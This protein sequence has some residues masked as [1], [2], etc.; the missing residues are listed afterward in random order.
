MRKHIYTLYHYTFK[1]LKTILD[2]AFRF[3]LNEQA[4]TKS[5]LLAKIQFY[6]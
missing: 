1:I 3:R 5:E 4:F 6:E 2:P